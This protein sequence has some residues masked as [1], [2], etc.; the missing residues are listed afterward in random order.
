MKL[1]LS[2]RVAIVLEQKLAVMSTVSV[3]FRDVQVKLE[4]L[5]YLK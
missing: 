4:P 3:N 5:S 1:R 2:E